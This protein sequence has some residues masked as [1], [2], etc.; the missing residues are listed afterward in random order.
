MICT[1]HWPVILQS[2]N[3]SSDFFLIRKTLGKEA[4]FCGKSPWENLWENYYS[5]T[6]NIVDGSKLGFLFYLFYFNI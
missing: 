3:S 1:W 5:V 2:D 6:V 4:I